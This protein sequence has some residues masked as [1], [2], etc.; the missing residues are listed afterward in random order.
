LR[1]PVHDTSNKTYSYYYYWEYN[2][3]NDSY[4]FRRDNVLVYNYGDRKW[5]D[6]RNAGTYPTSSDANEQTISLWS[7]SNRLGVFNNPYY[8]ASWVPPIYGVYAIEL[9]NVVTGTVSQHPADVVPSLTYDNYNKITL[10]QLNYED[11][12]TVS[13]PNGSIHEIGTAKTMY[14]K[15]T[16][17]Y[18]FKIS[19]TDKYAE[20]NVYVSSVD[21]AG[22]PTKPIDF[23]GYNKLTLIDAGS[24]VSAN[25]T[26]FS[27]TYELGSANVLYINGAGTY[28]LEM[29][30]SNVFALSS[31]VVGTVSQ[32]HP[33]DV[34]PSLTFDNYNKLTLE[35]FTTTESDTRTAKL[36][37][38]NDVEYSLGQTQN[39]IYIEDTGE[40]ILEVTNSDQSAVVK[41]NVGTISDFDPSSQWT[42]VIQMGVKHNISSDVYS[43]GVTGTK[44]NWLNGVGTYNTAS[45]DNYV[46]TWDRTSV[47]KFLWRGRDGAWEILFSNDV[48]DNFT[49]Y[50]SSDRHYLPVISGKGT[51]NLDTAGSVDVS[52]I[53]HM[54]VFGYGHSSATYPQMYFTNNGHHSGRVGNFSW[55]E[56]SYGWDRDNLWGTNHQGFEVLVSTSDTAGHLIDAVSPS[57]TFDGYNKLSIENLNPD[58]I[59]SSTWLE[60][61]RYRYGK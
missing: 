52:T 40:Y 41:T 7:G 10:N 6:G 58:L 27:N 8:D 22:A 37:D 53:T 25:V 44:S 9:S 24:N 29:S 35:N 50:W 33:T 1:K 59:K 39:D 28:D 55:M 11:T 26:Y 31:N 30:G 17:E 36:T 61:V 18:V 20:S 5:Y 13:D 57:L 21:L 38:P 60:H 32:Q 16:G 23:D 12:A 42:K 46:L 4:D 54:E 51:V 14:V 3:N 43:N 2:S 15:D 56:S 48:L 34:V 49:S 47:K 45:D 19:G